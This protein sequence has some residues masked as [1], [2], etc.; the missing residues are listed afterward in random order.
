MTAEYLTTKAARRV[1]P[2]HIVVRWVVRQLTRNR[3][4]VGLPVAK[5]RKVMD[6]AGSLSFIPRSVTH[7]HDSLGG[8]EVD[9]LR[10]KDAANGSVM[11]Y[12]HGGGYV[13]GNLK[14]HGELAGKLAAAASLNTVMPDYRLA[15]EHPFPAAMD[16]ALACYKALLDSGITANKILVGG[17]S[18][19][20]GLTLSLLLKL[21]ELGIEQPAAA[22]LIS[23]LTDLTFSG[24]SY[25][26]REAVDPLLTFDW[27]NYGAK[28][29]AGDNDLTHPLLSPLFAD[30]TG[31]P[32][33]M[34]QVGDDEI[35]LDDSVRF[36]E[37]AHSQ[38]V[39]I[40]ATVW[41]KMW[42]DFQASGFGLSEQA[43]AIAEFGI[44]AAAHLKSDR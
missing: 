26:S 21:K 8:V 2:L 17:D 40:N 34:I 10:P 16:D 6:Q 23:P 22:Y 19:G 13:L 7:L 1:G 35:L 28:A 14:T 33:L 36:A 38:G 29:Y 39:S 44:F 18:A 9:W 32:P 43:E 11:L 12:L 3:L 37:K 20:G 24:G 31:L 15:P 30:L 27:L 4:T 25:Q 41:P 5:Q 42:H